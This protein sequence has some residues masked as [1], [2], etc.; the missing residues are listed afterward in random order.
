[1]L[2]C[3]ELVNKEGK[4]FPMSQVFHETVTMTERC[5][6]LGYTEVTTLSDGPLGPRGTKGRGHEF[7]YSKITECTSEHRA[8]AVSHPVKEGEKCPI[9]VLTNGFWSS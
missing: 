9:N 1:M 5:Q 2:L 7:H 3:R 4:A 6:M 8:Y